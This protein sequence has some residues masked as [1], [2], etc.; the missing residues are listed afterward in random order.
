MKNYATAT[1]ALSIIGAAAPTILL[2]IAIKFKGILLF[3]LI[4]SHL[5][6]EK[7]KTTV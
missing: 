2:I 6:T 5:S 7:V 3:S 1:L 4:E